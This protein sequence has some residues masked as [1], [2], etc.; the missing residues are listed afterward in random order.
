MLLLPWAGLPWLVGLDR[1]A[2]RGRRVA[3]PGAARRRAAP[4]R[5]RERVVAGAGRRSARC[6]G[7]CCE[8]AGPRSSRGRSERLGTVAVLAVG[9]VAVVDRRAAP[10][11]VYGLPVL[12]LTENLET[13]AAPRPRATSCAA[14]A[15]GSSTGGTGSGYSIDQAEPTSTIGPR[16]RRHLRLPAVRPGGRARRAVAPTA[17][18]SCRSSLVGTVV[19]VGAWPFDDPSP[20]GRAW[21]SFTEETSVGLAFRNSPRAVP[22]V[23]L[24]L[25][26][27]L[28][29]LV[30]AAPAIAWRRGVAGAVA[31]V[32]LAGLLPVAVHGYLT[33]FLDATGGP[34]DPLGR[35]GRA[36]RRAATTAR[37]SWRSPACPSPPTRG[38]RPW[39]R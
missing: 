29:A 27:L 11:G 22:L 20:Y 5:R 39:I 3:R 33:D 18:A 7:C 24:G 30:E 4:R 32:A 14:S 13:V 38:G 17:P 9:G 8:L 16:G 31:A 15:T 36:A 21:R 19:S 28:A 6:C 26:G 23:V 10:A 2:P 12:Q 34:P 37:G 25:A 35:G 1:C